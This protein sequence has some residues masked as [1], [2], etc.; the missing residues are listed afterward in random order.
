MKLSIVIV[1][2]NVKYFVAQCLLSVE[3]ALCGLNAEVFVVDNASTDGS[4]AYLR[5]KFPWVRFIENCEN[6]GFAKANNQAVRQSRGEYV[7][8]LN[9]DTFV[10]E[11]TLRECIDL[12]DQTPRAGMCGVAMLKVDG[13]FA[14]ESRRGV[15]TPWVSFCKMS[16]LGSLFPKSRLF[17]RYYMQYLN[18]AAIC[19]IDIVSG[20]FMFIRREA[21]DKV[22]LL[23]EAF[24]M[25]GED[26]DLSYRVLKAGYENYYLP[27]QILHYKGESTKKDS[28]KYINTFYRAMLIFFRK[29]FS[30]YSVV[31]SVP[32]TV[33]IAMKGAM[34]YVVQKTKAWRRRRQAAVRLKLLLV[35]DGQN[36]EEMRQIAERYRL[37]YDVFRLHVG[38][39]PS[40]DVLYR[41]YDYIVFDTGRYAFGDILRFFRNDGE[42][43]KPYIGT[44]IPSSKLIMTFAGALS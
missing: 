2:Y 15:P 36:L 10:G 28:L 16:G 14:P 27:A 43:R 18:R 31:Y 20:A 3:R 25:Y 6:V 8:L 21:L 29:H 37:V 42:R 35:S 40:T 38:D 24:Y 34:S 19:K 12:M 5:S 9:P 44:Y 17:G 13:S 23:D 1:N 30:Y 33:A 32:I 41:D 4:V 11:S 7:L 39:M 26:V 22:G